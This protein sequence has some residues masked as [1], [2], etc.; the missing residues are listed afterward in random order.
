MQEAELLKCRSVAALALATAVLSAGCVGP[1]AARPAP[2]PKIQAPA[3]ASGEAKQT[4]TTRK[5]AG[6]AKATKTG[7]KPH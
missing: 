2:A 3:A 4:A 1:F 5:H 7:G 6:G